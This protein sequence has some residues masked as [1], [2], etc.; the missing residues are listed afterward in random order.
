MTARMS[1]HRSTLLNAPPRGRT[2]RRFKNGW[3]ERLH[4]GVLLS[5]R[6]LRPQQSLD[7]IPLVSCHAHTVSPTELIGRHG[8]FPKLPGFLERDQSVVGQYRFRADATSVGRGSQVREVS[9]APSSSDIAA[10][11]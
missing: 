4:D 5:K 1:G 3:V 10:N 2:A 11:W 7:P 6:M 9:D 8:K